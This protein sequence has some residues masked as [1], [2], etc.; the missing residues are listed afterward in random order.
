MKI[1]PFKY[2]GSFHVIPFIEVHYDGWVDETG[3]SIGWLDRGL[4]FNFK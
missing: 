3:L 2:R 4:F 1:Y